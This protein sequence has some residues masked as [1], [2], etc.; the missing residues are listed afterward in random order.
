MDS[1]G[2][3][4]EVVG[5]ITDNLYAIF[6][7]TLLDIEDQDGVNTSAWEPKNLVKFTLDSNLA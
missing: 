6:A 1:N 7:Y 3:E 5:R 4:L 2:V